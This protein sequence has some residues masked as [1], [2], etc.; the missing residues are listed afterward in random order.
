[1][2]KC[3]GTS[4]PATIAQAEIECSSRNSPS[5]PILR[6]FS[7]NEIVVNTQ[8]GLRNHAVRSGDVELTGRCST[9]I[10]ARKM[11]MQQ[12]DDEYLGMGLGQRHEG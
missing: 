3:I 1:M 11:L 5:P 10:P 8:A 6:F 4:P 12:R 7:G 2:A 9:A